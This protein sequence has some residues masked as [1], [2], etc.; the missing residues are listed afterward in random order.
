[1]R[2]VIQRVKQASV[3]VDE[4]IVGIIEK[5]L[6]V[7]LGIDKGDN[8]SQSE[9]IA[10]KLVNL[11]IFSDENGKMNKS[12]KDIDG[13]MLVVSQFTLSGDCRKGNRPSFDTAEHPSKAK[14]LYEEFVE[15]I[16]NHGVGVETGEFG[17]MMDVSLVNDGPVTFV[18]E[19]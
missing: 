14:P 6:L 8:L 18:I 16:K 17:A 10:K 1:M 19:K 9:F 3:S 7:L 4:K 12:I 15:L 5:G 2:V 11:R 13:K